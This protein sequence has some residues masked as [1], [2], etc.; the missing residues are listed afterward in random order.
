M[1]QAHVDNLFKVDLRK[2][3]LWTLIFLAAL[4]TEGFIGSQHAAYSSIAAVPTSPHPG[5]GKSTQIFGNGKFN[6]SSITVDTIISDRSGV[7]IRN[8]NVGGKNISIA[9]MCKWKIP[10]KINQRGVI[11]DP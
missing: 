4:I 11:L 5:H 2:I 3:C 1:D 6:K 10:C 7:T 9:A 8:G